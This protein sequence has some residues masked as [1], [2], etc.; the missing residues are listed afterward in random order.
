MALQGLPMNFLRWILW[1]LTLA[2]WVTLFVFTHLP[3]IRLPQVNVSDKLEHFLAYGLLCGMMGLTLWVA[4]PTRR[5]VYRLPLL[6][7]L[8]AAA[9]GAF[10]EITQPL[11]RRTADVHDWLADCGGALAAA[12][13]LFVLQKMFSS[14]VSS[15]P[16]ASASPA[17]VA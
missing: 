9:Y 3:P 11:T 5:W 13:V 15:R 1:A 12:L 4:F 6:I 2:Y 10:D 8:G 7:V 17:P 16:T 14:R